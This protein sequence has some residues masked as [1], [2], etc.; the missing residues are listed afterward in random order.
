MNGPEY[1]QANLDRQDDF[2][3]QL[4]RAMG[5]V[6]AP[7]GF[8]D[9]L[10]MRAANETRPSARLFAMPNRW[11]T[12]Q[13]WAAG[14]LAATLLIGVSVQQMHHHQERAEA[15]RQFEVATQIEQQALDRTREKLSR[16]GIFLDQQ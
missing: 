12:M 14:A 8:A 3:H 9:A 13:M 7:Q 1:Q 16:S 4:K 2:E 5:R 11:R 10:L 15:T 6:D